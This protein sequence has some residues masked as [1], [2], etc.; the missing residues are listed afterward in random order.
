MRE[1]EPEARD[2]AIKDASAKVID[3]RKEFLMRMS[4]NGGAL[5]LTKQL[6]RA[7]EAGDTE[8]AMNITVNMIDL[9][10]QGE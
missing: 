6:V 4:A 7:I 5:G 10:N 8:A 2:G 3:M 9:V 1:L